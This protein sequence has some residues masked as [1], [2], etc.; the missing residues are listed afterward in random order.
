MG[1][2]TS[3]QS[4]LFIDKYSPT[5]DLEQESQANEDDDHDEE[6]WLIIQACH[7]YPGDEEGTAGEWYENPFNL[8]QQ[9]SVEL[10]WD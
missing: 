3:K 8:H 10:S 6:D 1:G 4:K 7:D 5:E 2:A 9:V